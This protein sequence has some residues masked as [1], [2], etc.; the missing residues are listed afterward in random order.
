EI[1]VGGK[2][3]DV[4]V[5]A[6]RSRSLPADADPRIRELIENL[7]HHRGPGDRVGLITFGTKP[8]IESVLSNESRL[9]AYTKEILADGSDL[10][11][12]L[13]EALNLVQH[14]RPARILV[15]SDGEANGA[16][17]TAA[18]RRA[19][20]LGVPVD[21]RQFPRPRAA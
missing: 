18:A 5:V 16:S 20:D 9:Q 10:N 14:D 11:E 6:D 13:H 19:S 7:Q 3:I 4:I 15:F 2:G 21:F 12:A 8:A 1:N 17:P